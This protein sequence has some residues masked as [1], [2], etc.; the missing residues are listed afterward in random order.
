MGVRYPGPISRHNRV[1]P[2][3]LL[4]YV[5]PVWDRLC[6]AMMVVVGVFGTHGATQDLALRGSWSE[7]PGRVHDKGRVSL[8]CF[9]PH[10]GSARPVFRS[11][12]V[13]YL[14]RV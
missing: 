3:M 9:G 4:W 5:V 2:L 6:F 1:C 8:G 13:C 10:Y 14:C 7:W 11:G 12:K